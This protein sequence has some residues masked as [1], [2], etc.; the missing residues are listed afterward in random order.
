MPAVLVDEFG[1][2]V[3]D[4]V[5]DSSSPEHD[6]T[7][8]V[9]SPTPALILLFLFCPLLGVEVASTLSDEVVVDPVS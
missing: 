7:C 1:E 2:G 4:E 5:V 9:S 8:W 3:A 6:G